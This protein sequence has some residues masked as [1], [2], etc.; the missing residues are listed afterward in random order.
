MQALFA[1]YAALMRLHKPI[2]I[3]LLFFPAAWATL[4]SPH[5]TLE[6]VAVMLLGAGYMR[7]AGCIIND[8]TDR[9][10]DR[11]VARTKRRPLAAGTVS[12]DLATLLLAALLVGA[13]YLALALPPHV[14]WIAVLAVP[15]V[16]AYPWMKRFTH[17]PQLFLAMTF[18]L[19][20]PIGWVATHTP[21][22]LAPALIYLACV[23]W[24]LA[25]DTIYALQDTKDDARLGIKSSALRL[26]KRV[27]A[28]AACCFMAMLLLLALAGW[29]S[30]ASLYYYLGL[31]VA[32]LHMRW[33]I[34]QLRAR[35]AKVAGELFESNQWLGLAVLTGLLA[36][37]VLG[38][39]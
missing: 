31:T 39:G 19:G 5:A 15:M 36:Q 17:W 13:L 30:K 1:E 9:K 32:G 4:L 10:L 8:M 26:G 14:M 12:A 28:F 27:P 6:I 18:N 11:H 2:G 38:N 34:Q 24:T 7:A 35:G 23:F 29:A 37:L 16:I 3:W 25:Y 20:V 21:L 33:Q 22:T